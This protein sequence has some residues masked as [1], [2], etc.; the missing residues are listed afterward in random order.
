MHQ[1]NISHS[2]N[3]SAC[4]FHDEKIGIDIERISNV[5]VGTISKN[6]HQQEYQF[7]ES[8][9]FSEEPFFKIWTQKE[10]LLK[11][12]GCGIVDGLNKYSCVKDTVETE[13]G[14]F[15]FQEVSVHPE[16]SMHI[17]SLSPVSHKIRWVQPEQVLFKM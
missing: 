16:Y 7:L 15:Y 5:D 8:C 6:F 2:G 1:F 10:A 9:Q 3:F 13:F 4:I 17:A 12:C 14:L 11:A